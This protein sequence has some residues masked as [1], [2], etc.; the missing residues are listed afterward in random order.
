MHI[1]R[2]ILAFLVAL[3]LAMLPMAGTF[4]ASGDEAMAS[5]VVVAS[6][7]GDCDHAAMD[8]DAVVKSIHECCNH[9]AM[10]THSMNGCSGSADCIAKCLGLYAVL[11]SSIAIAC[12]FGGT[13]PGFV[14]NPFHSRVASPPFRPPRI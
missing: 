8:S 12:A 2:T 4:V 6:A 11:F 1:G 10:P 14:S 13:E 7:H 3:S 9:A 5:E